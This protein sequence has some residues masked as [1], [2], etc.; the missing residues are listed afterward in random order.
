MLND[1]MLPLNVINVIPTAT[2]PM[3]DTV[4]KSDLMLVAERNP[5]VETANNTTPTAAA[6]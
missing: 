2:Q 4:V 3:K 1:M 5:G 6:H